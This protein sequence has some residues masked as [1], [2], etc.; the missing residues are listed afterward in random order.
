[1]LYKYLKIFLRPSTYLKMMI[2]VLG[3]LEVQKINHS[4][5]LFFNKLLFFKLLKLN[6]IKFSAQFRFLINP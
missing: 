3:K 4:K 5:I 2:F 6:L 1:M